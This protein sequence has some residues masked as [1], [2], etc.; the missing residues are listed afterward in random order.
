ME[1]FITLFNSIKGTYHTI[2]FNNEEIEAAKALPMF[3]QASQQELIR[4][5]Y[6]GL[7]DND[8][9]DYNYKYLIKMPMDS[10]TEE[11]VEKLNKEHGNKQAELEIIKKTTINKMW[12]NELDE[13]KKQYIEYKEE[14][15]MLMNGTPKKK[16]VSKTSVK[17]VAKK[18]TLVVE[19]D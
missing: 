16:V 8:E 15:I 3:Q 1:N 7:M 9:N 11:N 4:L 18:Q 13:L 5:I 19:D 10:V 14:R 17:K 6:D 2:P 12:L